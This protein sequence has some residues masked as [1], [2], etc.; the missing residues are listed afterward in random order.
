ML[1]PLGRFDTRLTVNS[2]N[3]ISDLMELW[4]PKQIVHQ[5]QFAALIIEEIW[6]HNFNLFP[7]N[8][9]SLKGNLL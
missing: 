2:C 4:K 6:T 9:K 7:P 3:K 8:L 5:F 1:K